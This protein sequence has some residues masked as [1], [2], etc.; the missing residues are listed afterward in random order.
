MKNFFQRLAQR[1]AAWM[2]GR[3]GNDDLGNALVALG[4]ITMLASILPRCG[5]LSYVALAAMAVAIWR[6]CSKNV[7]KRRQENQKY[8]RLSAKPRRSY[9]LGK[10]KWSNRKTTKY[11]RCKHCGQE[12]SVPRGKGTMRVV[13]PK[14]KTETKRHFAENQ[15]RECD[16]IAPEKALFHRIPDARTPSAPQRA[17]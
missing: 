15:N 5:W 11:F 12:L 14:C 7:G 1:T 16:E 3:Y 8:L 6:T 17:R 2:Q 4:I 9:E 10:K 13:C